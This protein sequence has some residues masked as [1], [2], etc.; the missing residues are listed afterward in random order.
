MAGVVG[1]VVT[2]RTVGVAGLDSLQDYR[3]RRKPYTPST[4]PNVPL[5]KNVEAMSPAQLAP[6]GPCLVARGWEIIQLGWDKTA[7][8][9]ARGCKDNSSF[10]VDTGSALLCP[11][12]VWL[13]ICAL[14]HTNSKT[15]SD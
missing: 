8:Y 14:L 10:F 7:V 1:N 5:R 3:R 2:N 11:N 6:S 4:M 12:G 9:Y 13:L 15:E